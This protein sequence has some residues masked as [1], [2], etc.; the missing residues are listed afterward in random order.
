MIPY[1]QHLYS[2]NLEQSS[3]IENQPYVLQITE[4]KITIPIPDIYH[5]M[6]SKTQ[7]LC[8]CAETIISFAQYIDI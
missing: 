4:I 6:R 7:F 8:I 1:I 3:C 5:L 2:L